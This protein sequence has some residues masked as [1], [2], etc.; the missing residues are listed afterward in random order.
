MVTLEPRKLEK[1]RYHASL[2][3]KF[4]TDSEKRRYHASL[5]TKFTTDSKTRRYHA[6]LKIEL[7]GKF[8]HFTSLS[9]RKHR[10]NQ[11]FGRSIDQ[12]AIPRE[13]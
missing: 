8:Q 12:N 6:S 9:R 10:K 11:Q 3:T 1:R 7:N 4:T 5:V 13:F 2:V